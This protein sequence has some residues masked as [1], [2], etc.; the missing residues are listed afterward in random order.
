MLKAVTNRDASEAVSHVENE[1]VDGNILNLPGLRDTSSCLSTPKRASS[2]VFTRDHLE[3][4][5]SSEDS[6]MQEPEHKV[7][8]LEV[9]DQ[10]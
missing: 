1:D 6:L 9:R 10:S 8:R 5:V 7:T 2:P 3:V 4:T